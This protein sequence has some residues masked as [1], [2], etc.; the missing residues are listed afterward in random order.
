MKEYIILV[1][2]SAVLAAFA[3]VLSPK[4]W[5]GYIRVITG[6]LIL[7][8]LLSPVAKLKDIEV[9]SL[10]ENLEVSD[11]KMKDKV[12]EEL[13]K[14]VEQDIE[15]RIS[16]EFEGNADVSVDIAIDDGHKIKG[17]E[18]IV[19]KSKKIPKGL[20]ERLKEVYGCE[21]VE[22]RLE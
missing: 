13:K 3:D 18:R 10:D 7:A 20:E 14:N 21:N 11:V 12:A 9:F 19:I 8:V 1:A 6:F 15:E 22:F 16:A 2:V 17:V 5:R 4:E